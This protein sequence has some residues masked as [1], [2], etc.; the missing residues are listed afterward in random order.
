MT[1]IS[2]C[3]RQ[4][5]RSEGDKAKALEAFLF[6][7]REEREKSENS[8]AREVTITASHDRHSLRARAAL[9]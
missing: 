3:K 1:F 8:F 5:R 4:A 2:F 6:S 7:G 9:R